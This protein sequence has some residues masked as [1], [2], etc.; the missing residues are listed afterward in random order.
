MS[1]GQAT[2][3]VFDSLPHAMQLAFM[4]QD[5]VALEQSL[6]AM[7]R[8]RAAFYMQRCVAVGLW[9]QTNA[10]GEELA[11]TEQ[12]AMNTTAIA[13]SNANSEELGSGSSSAAE[14]TANHINELEVAT[15]VDGAAR[16][17]EE[18]DWNCRGCG[19][20][21][22]WWRRSCRTCLSRTNRTRSTTHHGGHGHGHAHGNHNHNGSNKRRAM[23]RER[24]DRDRD[25]D[26]HSH[27][28]SYSRYHKKQTSPRRSPRHSPRHNRSRSRLHTPCHRVLVSMG[29][30]KYIPAFVDEGWTDIAGWHSLDDDTLR[31]DLNFKTGDVERFNRLKVRYIAA[32][33]GSTPKGPSGSGQRSRDR[34][35]RSERKSAARETVAAVAV[36][37]P[38]E[39]SDRFLRFSRDMA[40]TNMDRLVYSISPISFEGGLDRV[41][42][43]IYD[44]CFHCIPYDMIPSAVHN[45]F[46]DALC[47]H[48][49]RPLEDDHFDDGVSD[50]DDVSTAQFERRFV[51]DGGR[52][53]VLRV[54][55]DYH[56]KQK[57]GRNRR[58][59]DNHNGFGGAKGKFKYWA[60]FA[61]ALY[62]DRND[63]AAVEGSSEATT[64]ESENGTKVTPARRTRSKA[65]R[66]RNSTEK[67]TNAKETTMSPV[68][69][70]AYSYSH[71]KKGGKTK[72]ERGKGREKK[73]TSP[74]QR[75]YS[76]NL[77]FT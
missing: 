61:L 22:W 47:G 24:G 59:R 48:L 6:I 57:R 46:G 23:N 29:L 32:F 31:Y 34:R 13:N 11:V 10:D 39:L 2:Q 60:K 62:A 20:T 53:F 58:D 1:F 42:A 67:E 5:S 28:N 55:T 12:M 14:L 38:E 70:T 54:M 74:G 7:D 25:R 8:E 21:N 65:R 37:K 27:S 26:A 44:F 76:C 50:R 66:R 36:A 33:A 17:F 3:D 45:Y 9:V 52:A 4:N 49:T 43:K 63:K 71:N 56:V 41:H 19:T 15:V 64:N 68:T 72:S 77:V 30:S 18:I 69:P 40:S 35:D 75:H 73:R 51:L 16:N